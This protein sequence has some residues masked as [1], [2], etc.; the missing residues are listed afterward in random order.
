MTALCSVIFFVLLVAVLSWPESHSRRD[1][2]ISSALDKGEVVEIAET[3]DGA[4][5]W[6]VRREG[7][8]I[9]FSKGSVAIDIKSED[10]GF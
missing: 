4:R 5:L 7:K 1:K 9:Y 2:R 3:T 10:R 8:T 6:A